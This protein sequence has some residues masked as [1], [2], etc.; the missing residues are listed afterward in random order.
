MKA[1]WSPLVSDVSGS[2]GQVV[3]SKNRYGSYLRARNGPNHSAAPNWQLV[4]DNGQYLCSIWQSLSLDSQIA[5]SQASNLH[6]KSYAF[7]SASTLPGYNYFLSVN[8]NR[9]LFSL[10]EI[11]LPP[12]YEVA[13]MPASLTLAYNVATQ[14]LIV[15]LAPDSLPNYYTKLFATPPLSSGKSY[16]KNRLGLLFLAWSSRFLKTFAPGDLL[17][18]KA[19][20]FNSVGCTVSQPFYIRV[21]IS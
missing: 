16:F 2:L 17:F 8:Q 9:L 5:W 15:N 13:E 11:L 18:F 14:S 12:V 19:V 1:L 3:A 20:N 7:G 10:A 21:A 4:R 6:Q